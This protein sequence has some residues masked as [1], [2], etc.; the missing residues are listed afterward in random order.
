MANFQNIQ[1]NKKLFMIITSLVWAINFRATFENIGGHMDLGCYPTLKFDP[2]LILIKNVLCCII[3]LIIFWYSLYI[4]MSKIK[5][6]VLVTEDKE[7]AITYGYKEIEKDDSLID[8]ITQSH[9]LDSPI[10]KFFFWS[11]IILIIIIIYI[12]EEAFFMIANNHFLDRLSVCMRNIGI[13]ILVL[14]SSLLIKKSL[15]F[16]KHQ[17]YPSIIIIIC[18]LFMIIFN[19]TTIPRFKKIYNI[20]FLYYLIVFGLTG[21]ELVLIKYLVEKEFISI[22]L[23]LGLK[24]LFGTITF[25]FINIFINESKFFYYFDELLTFE[26]DDMYE[27]FPLYLKIIYVISYLILQYL[28]MATIDELSENHFL[29][30]TLITDVFC[31]PLYLIEKFFVQKFPISTSVT[32]YLNTIIGILNMILLL[33]F[34]EII[35]IK[36][37]GVE[38]NTNKNIDKR[39]QME[40]ELMNKDIKNLNNNAYDDNFEEDED[41]C[42][43]GEDKD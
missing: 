8:S 17:L 3:N 25:G 30:I 14:L 38:K 36:C 9:R 4:N 40:I 7:N 43:E 6:K 10:A 41:N 16:N 20:N 1:T 23:I 28:K 21:V 5:D 34:N 18:S 39:Q 19:A 37:F 33:I 32:F 27:E 11:K 24:G 12:I 31:F 15:H 35:E 2:I 13:L 42:E 26:Y 22:F 29:S